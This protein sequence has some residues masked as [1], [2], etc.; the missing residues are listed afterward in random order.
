[1]KTAST[2]ALALEVLM[3]WPRGKRYASELLDAACVRSELSGANAAFLHDMVLAVIRNLS[4]LDHWVDVLSDG[5]HLDHRTRWVLRLGLAQML[6]I[7]VPA[8]AA[9]NETVSIAGKAR[10]L[11]NALL[12][13]ADRERESLLSGANELSLSARLSHPSWLV[14]RWEKDLGASAAAALCEWNQQPAVTYVRVNP[15]H[16]SANEARDFLEGAEDV[17]EGFFK[18]THPPREALKR[19]LCYAHDPSTALAVKLLAPQPGETVLD[20]C[21]A[22]GGKTALMAAMMN[23]EGR[24]IAC[25]V[26]PGRIQRLKDNLQRLHVRNAEVLR[27]DLASDAAPP[28][29]DVQFDRILLDVP[30]SNTGVMRRRVDVRWRL[31]DGDF[32]RLADMQAHLLHQSLRFLKPGGT[33]VYSTCSVDAEENRGVVDRVVAM[34]PGLKLEDETQ[35]V[36]PAGVFDGAYAARLVRG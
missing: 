21:A 10:S 31:Q 23:N 13:R 24:I 15:L 3:E 34:N 25:D 20:A 2:R 32:K 18:C 7:A 16:P 5:K 6:L 33:L 36:P 19:G 29:G 4:L 30:C 27:H 11:V 22:P 12:R 26:A 28:W 9:V 8:H 17:G 1:L 14:A 35:S